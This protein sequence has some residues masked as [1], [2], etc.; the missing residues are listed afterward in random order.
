MLLQ[1]CGCNPLLVFDIPVN[2]FA[3]ES[4]PADFDPIYQPT[5][6]P[7]QTMSRRTEKKLKARKGEEGSR[8]SLLLVLGRVVTEALC[9]ILQTPIDFLREAFFSSLSTKPLLAGITLTLFQPAI[10]PVAKEER[11]NVYIQVKLNFGLIAT[12][13]PIV[14]VMAFDVHKRLWWQS[15]LLV[16]QV[17]EGFGI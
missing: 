3:F 7:T 10:W 4:E 8:G 2:D 15:R 6:C 13:R 14:I 16:D 11:H 17:D 5:E 9:P 1:D 12:F